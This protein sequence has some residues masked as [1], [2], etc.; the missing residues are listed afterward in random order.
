MYIVVPIF[1]LLS[2][3]HLEATA[4]AGGSAVSPGLRERLHVD[5]HKTWCLVDINDVK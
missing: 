5:P 1:M 4:A 2:V 3:L